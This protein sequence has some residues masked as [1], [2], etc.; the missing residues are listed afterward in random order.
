MHSKVTVINTNN[1]LDYEN[2]PRNV[3]SDIN[4][5]YK[6]NICIQ[7]GR[8]CMRLAALFLFCII[9]NWLVGGSELKVSEVA[10]ASTWKL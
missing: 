6:P 3:F 8:N 9:I 5:I 4:K 1:E 2:I 7:A 10:A